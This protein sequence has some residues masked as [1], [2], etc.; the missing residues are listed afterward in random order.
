M[1]ANVCVTWR[2]L[3]VLACT[4][5]ATN[6]AATEDDHDAIKPQ[7]FSADVFDTRARA[8]LLKRRTDDSTL[9]QNTDLKHASA[10]EAIQ[11]LEE[12]RVHG[13]IEPEDYVAPKRAPM[14]EFRARLDRQ[15]PRTPQEIVKGALCMV[16]LCAGLP[17]EV[18]PEQRTE[19]RTRQTFTPGFGRGTLQ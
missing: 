12:I 11:H 9:K 3:V 1:C 7:Q 13:A 17:P 19:A 6:S 10:S 18:A 2:V 4:A 5:G 16:G 8:W 14:L 15:R